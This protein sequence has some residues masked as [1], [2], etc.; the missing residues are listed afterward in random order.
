MAWSSV[1]F[2][3]PLGPMIAVVC[4]AGM[5]KLA[6]RMATWGPWASVSPCRGPPA[7]RNGDGSR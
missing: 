4:P 3:D 2:P 1:D 7:W 6:S 5:V